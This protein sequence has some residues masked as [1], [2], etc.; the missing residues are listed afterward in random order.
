MCE[1]I[2]PVI[3]VSVKSGLHES[4]SLVEEFFVFGIQRKTV[5][6]GLS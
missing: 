2:P 3:V 6:A 1:T 4:S 5:K